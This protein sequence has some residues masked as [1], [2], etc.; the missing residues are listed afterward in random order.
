MN[1]SQNEK[2][3]ITRFAPSPTGFLHIGG[4][5][6]AIFNYLFTKKNKGEFLLRIDDTDKERSKKE[7]EEEI[8]SSLEKLGIK[9]DRK[10]IHQSER[11]VIYRG[12]VEKMIEQNF[13]YISKEEIGERSEVIRFRNPNKKIVFD[14]LVRGRVEFQTDDLGDFV[15]AKSLEEPVYH[16]ASVIDDYEYGITHIIRAEEHLSNT[17]RQILL[18]EAIGAPRPI[19]AHIPLVLAKD[20]SKL[21]KRYGAVNVNEFIS[22]GYEPEAMVNYLTLLG[23]HPNDEQ[24]IFTLKELISRFDLEKVQ[25]GGAIWDE[26]KLD[27]VNKEHL[28][29]SKIDIWKSLKDLVRE[30]DSKA[31]LVDSGLDKVTELIFERIVK[32]TDFEKILNSGEFEFF[33]KEP[34]WIE[35]DFLWKGQGDLEKTS[36][37]LKKLLEIINNLS[38]EEWLKEKIKDAIW[39]FAEEEGRGDVL[40]PFRYSLSGLQ[41]SPDPFVI[42]EIFGKDMTLNRL[43]G[44]INFLQK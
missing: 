43:S 6:T 29:K 36:A 26:V 17:P 23:W 18:L 16:L 24:E 15:I 5:R 28:K 9:S 8:I 41:K 39:S 11:V 38:Q 35:N 42:A 2:M 34:K 33:F 32:K 37:R 40:W 20:R 30:K 13:A 21:S 4:A 3:I 10:I 31:I 27:W 19:Y 7:F 14:D 25:K 1:N 44:A 12:F 22:A